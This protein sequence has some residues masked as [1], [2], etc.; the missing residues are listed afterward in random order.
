MILPYILKTYRYINII[1][2]VY[3]SVWL[4]VWPQN[5][6]RSL[7]L[8]FHGPV[9][10]RYILKTIWCMNIILW[11]YGSV[12]PNGWPQNKCRS[13]RPLFHGPVILSSPSIWC[14]SVIFADNE[15]VWPKLWPQSKYV[16]MTY[17]SW[18][19]NFAKCPQ[20]FLM[21]E[22]HSWFNGSMWH[23]DWPY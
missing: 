19:S 20:D 11:D 8:I 16:N 18:S 15:T 4:E 7:W 14:M 12:W 17:I 13:I 5:K 3:E 6:Y 9:I 2:W 23:I 10:L 1:I 21:D 22:H